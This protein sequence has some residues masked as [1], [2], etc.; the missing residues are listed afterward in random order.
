MLR[1]KLEA[2]RNDLYQALEA[3][4]MD[5]GHPEVLKVSVA[6][7]E[8]LNL[9]LRH[10]SLH[11]RRSASLSQQALPSPDRLALAPDLWTVIA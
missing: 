6:F 9:Y 11:R 7:D 5:H 1:A 2:L 8:L 3:A 10:Q 4:G